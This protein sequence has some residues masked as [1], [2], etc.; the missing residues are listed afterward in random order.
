M[1]LSVI[2]LLLNKKEMRMFTASHIHLISHSLQLLL[3]GVLMVYY[4]PLFLSS[5][6]EF[7]FD[8]LG[9]S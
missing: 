1:Y 4:F 9:R 8:L 7:Y 6:L 3:I 5:A 2:K